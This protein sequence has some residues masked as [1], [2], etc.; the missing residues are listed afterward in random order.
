M[1]PPAAFSSQAVATVA[2]S[3]AVLQ[4]SGER[5]GATAWV[6]AALPRHIGFMDRTALTQVLATL[7]FVWRSFQSV[8][9]YHFHLLFEQV[10]Q[11]FLESALFDATGDGDDKDT[12]GGA[13]ATRLRVQMAERARPSRQLP[14]S[15]GT[16][17][18]TQAQVERFP[19][20]L[21]QIS[22]TFE[23][24]VCARHTFW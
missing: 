19:Q 3:V 23:R 10:H 9:T 1:T 11:F 20:T 8:G 22:A 16:V 2:W 13:L 12:A 6:W 17:S 7:F 4:L 15:A 18:R 21:R 24:N 14:L 5:S